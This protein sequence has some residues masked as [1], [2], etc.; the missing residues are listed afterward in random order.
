MP[1]ATRSPVELRNMFGQNLRILVQDHPSVSELARQLGINRTQFNRYLGGES[2]PR[3]DVL[4]RICNFFGVD[5]RILLEPVDRQMPDGKILN[6]PF[7]SE[8]LGRSAHDVD[9]NTFP[10]GLYRFSRRSFVHSEMFIVG[11]AYVFR[12]QDGVT[13]V[14]RFEAKDAMQFQGLADDRATR[15]FRG[16]VLPHEEGVSLAMA[17]RN[18]NTFTFNYLSRASSMEGNFWSGYVARSTRESERTERV[19]RLVFEHLGKNF[20]RI[21]KVARLAGFTAE[22]DLP[23]YHNHLLRTFEPFK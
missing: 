12:G 23:P 13:F 10:S 6:G 14:K 17:R 15:E 9:E 11:L 22:K 4:D 2:F 16:F 21:M 19:T 1:N 18:S 7:L 5:A 3:P 8:F 20:S